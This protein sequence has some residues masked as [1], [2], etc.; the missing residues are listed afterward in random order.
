MDAEHDVMAA[1]LAETRT[2]MAALE[3]SPGDGEAADGAG[4]DAST[5]ATSR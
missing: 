3:A 2:A 1:A 4:R 5:C